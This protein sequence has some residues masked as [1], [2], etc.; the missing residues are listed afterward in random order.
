MKKYLGL[1]LYFV[2]LVLMSYTFFYF[3]GK[4]QK[5]KAP[6]QTVDTGNQENLQNQ[7]SDSQL[8]ES[9]QTGQVDTTDD[10][11][12]G[13]SLDLEPQ[14]GDS[15]DFTG[16]L[17]T[18][19]ILTGEKNEKPTIETKLGIG[20]ATGDLVPT[21]PYDD[22]YEILW[23]GKLPAYQ[24]PGKDIYLKKLNSVDYEEEKS[25]I[26]QLIQK[27]WGNVKET[28]LFGDKQLFVNPDIY[29]QKVVIMLVDYN[30][31]LYLVTLPY[32]DYHKYK[33]YLKNVL[34]V[35]H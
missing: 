27:I 32:E 1:T 26:N 21:T 5:L 16:E 2:W 11:L 22:I 23:Y 9:I 4:Y 18:G 6:V 31:K 17:F 13:L 8:S 20:Q 14:T 12:S 33:D 25:N 28:N 30:G 10:V 34:F 15:Q 29:Y 7:T 3:S 24:I 35:N 19:N